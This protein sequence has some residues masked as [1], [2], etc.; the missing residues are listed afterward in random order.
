LP[1]VFHSF[2]CEIVFAHTARLVQTQAHDER[3]RAVFD[4]I[5]RPLPVLLQSRRPFAVQSLT[6]C[7]NATREHSISLL[8]RCNQCEAALKTP[9]LRLHTAG[10][11]PEGVERRVNQGPQTRPESTFFGTDRQFQALYLSNYS[12]GRR[13]M[14][15]ARV[16][17]PKSWLQGAR[18]VTKA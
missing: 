3:H 10:S 11:T 12:A 7:S 8:P 9:R 14:A 15:G 1:Q 13:T 16:T 2:Q 17:F 4:V 5:A 18:D 6:R